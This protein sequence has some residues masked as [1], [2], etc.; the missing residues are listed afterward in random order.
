MIEGETC[1]IL[2]NLDLEI[3]KSRFLLFKL[4]F[5]KFSGKSI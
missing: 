3:S 5:K 1:K 2:K 4:I